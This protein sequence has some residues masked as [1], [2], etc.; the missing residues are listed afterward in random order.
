M[1]NGTVTGLTL[2]AFALMVSL[3]LFA[4]GC[5]EINAWAGR[6]IYRRRLGGHLVCMEATAYPGSDDGS[7]IGNDVEVDHWR[8][9]C[10]IRLDGS[11]LFGF[12]SICMSKITLDQ[13]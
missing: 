3:H 9:Q 11:E 1:F 4:F 6:L 10:G 12:G 8:S 5:R 2:C 7:G 13:G